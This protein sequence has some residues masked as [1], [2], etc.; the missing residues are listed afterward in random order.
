[1][2]K[3]FV[4]AAALA[5]F[6]MPRVEAQKASARFV[7]SLAVEGHLLGAFAPC[8]NNKSVACLLGA[9]AGAE[10]VLPL[11]FDPV[12]VGVSLRAEWM[13][14]IPKSGSQLKGGFDI[15]AYPGVFARFPFKLGKM[16]FALQPEF[17]YGV[18]FK[19]PKSSDGSGIKKSYV[20]QVLGVA[21]DL[22]MAFP[23]MERLEFSFAPMAIMELEK[24][25]SVFELGLRTGVVW[26]FGKKRAANKVEPVEAA[27]SPAAEPADEAAVE[28]KP[29]ES[30]PEL[31]P[32]QELEL[33]QE[34][35][36][37]IETAEE[38]QPEEEE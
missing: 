38:A 29:V 24:N 2:K 4:V 10:F 35:E 18:S 6:A 31:E 19:R 32:E 28:E 26:H 21:A 23:G 30:Q 22:R 16:D 9:G 11:R 33:E 3:I 34:S 20:N 17:F 15:K 1:M 13:Q 25:A 37:E 5:A 36:P 12:S 27:P 14:F 7:D 8:G